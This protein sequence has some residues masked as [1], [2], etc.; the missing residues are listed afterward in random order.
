MYHTALPYTAVAVIFSYFFAFM[1]IKTIDLISW[2]KRFNT[3]LKK[4]VFS[5]EI[6]LILIFN[7]IRFLIPK[8]L[9]LNVMLS[10]GGWGVNSIALEKPLYQI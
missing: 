7:F 9:G 5:L 4:K 8:G 3:I 2:L 6:L 1:V 10:V